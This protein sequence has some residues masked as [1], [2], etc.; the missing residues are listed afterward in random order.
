M[1]FLNSFT[2]KTYVVIYIWNLNQHRGDGM[3]DILTDTPL[4]VTEKLQVLLREELA[5]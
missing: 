5:K 4:S 1:G 3:T 2:K